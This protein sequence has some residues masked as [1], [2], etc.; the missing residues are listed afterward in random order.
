LASTNTTALVSSN[1]AFALSLY[2]QLRTNDG[3]L[4]LSPYSISTCLAM[5][6]A[7]SHGDT[8]A[9]MSDVMGFETNQQQFASLYGQLQTQLESDQQTNA[10]E[11][12][13]ADALWTQEGFPFLSSFLETA[14]N[15]YQANVNQIDFSTEAGL[16]VQEIN[17]W[18]A[19]ETQ[20]NIQNILAPGSI[21]G[22]TRLVLANAIYF[23]GAWT[24]SFEVTNTSIQPFYLSS[25]NAVA[26]PLMYQPPP[27]SYPGG[28]LNGISYLSA[29]NFQAVEMPYASNQ[30]SMV[31]LLP[32]Q[33]DGLAQLEQELSPAFLSNVL[34]RLSPADCAVYLPRFTLETSFQLSSTLAEMG[35]PDAFEPGLADFSGID[36][37]TDLSISAVFHKAWVQVNEAGTE[38]AAATVV[39]VA[40][41]IP[42]PPPV[43]FRADHPFVFFIRDT[44]TGSILF[45][46]R[47]ANPGGSAPI[48]ALT[49]TP[50]SNKFKISWPNSF[51]GWSLV[52]S[53]DLTATS[54][55]PVSG[56]SNDGTNN[57]ITIIPSAGNVFFRLSQ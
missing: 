41:L 4:F 35:M 2:G 43:S 34:A 57:S 15:Q 8:A 24:A 31:I 55:T 12:N 28:G 49:V 30:L 53:S 18:V 51:K 16:A 29:S 25:S 40:D 54:W 52:Q 22:S 45:M 21:N 5:T 11:L 3:N 10:L 20:N 1:T 38:A 46:G 36:G 56:I 23:L 33:V 42:P 50:S 6:Y 7:G 17:D 44:Q 13:I 47:L 48:S 39:I 27:S 26:V 19:Q 9:Q 14:T 37:A 32:N